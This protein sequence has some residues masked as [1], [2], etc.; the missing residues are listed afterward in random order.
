MDKARIEKE[1]KEMPN[2]FADYDT[3][4]TFITEEELKEYLPI[5]DEVLT[6]V[7]EKYCD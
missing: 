6:M 7:D 2:Y 1:I 4:V 5:L 3:T